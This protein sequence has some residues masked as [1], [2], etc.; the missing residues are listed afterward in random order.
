[1]NERRQD[2]H[3]SVKDLFITGSHSYRDDQTGETVRASV[4]PGMV[5]VV[6]E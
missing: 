5:T 1:V 6:R 3:I 4:Y 2:V